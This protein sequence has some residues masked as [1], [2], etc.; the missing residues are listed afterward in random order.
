VVTDS[1][2]GTVFAVLFN[3]PFVTIGNSVRGVARFES[4]LNQLGLVDQL[5]ESPEQLT[6]ALLKQPV[7]WAAVNQ[8][9][10]HLAAAGRDFLRVHVAGAP[11][12]A[13][14]APRG[15]VLPKASFNQ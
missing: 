6:P 14:A 8:K 7:D 3:K 12:L 10:M 11:P 4:L 9:R 13:N 5:I 1:F 15:A 2:H